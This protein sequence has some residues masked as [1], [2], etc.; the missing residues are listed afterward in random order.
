VLSNKL[1]ISLIGQDATHDTVTKSLGSHPWIHIA[2]H[3]HLDTPRPF[4]SSFELHADTHLTLLDVV[5]AGL[6]TTTKLAFLSACHT[7]ESQDDGAPDEVLHLTAAV[8]FCGFRSV[9]GTMW[10]VADT[11]G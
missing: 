8:Q 7:A 10:A 3:G 5:H 11:D 1:A 4:C 9:V 6:P 2:C